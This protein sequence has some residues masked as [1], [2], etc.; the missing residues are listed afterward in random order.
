MYF[1]SN[2]SASITDKIVLE[3]KRKLLT[4]IMGQREY[5]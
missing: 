2:F 4:G 5:A 3:K 1:L